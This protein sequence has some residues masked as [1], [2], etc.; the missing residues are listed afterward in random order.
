MRPRG[1]G[2]GRKNDFDLITVVKERTYNV[3]VIVGRQGE[4]I[5]FEFLRNEKV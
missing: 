3:R 1:L 2:E 5:I 4:L